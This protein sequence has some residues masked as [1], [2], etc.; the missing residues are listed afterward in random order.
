MSNKT[1]YRTQSYGRGEQGWTNPYDFERRAK[2]KKE[3]EYLFICLF[4]IWVSTTL[5][6]SI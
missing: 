5:C 3:E 4:I 2:K 1:E 6:D